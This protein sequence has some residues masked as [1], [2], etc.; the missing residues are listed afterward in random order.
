MWL[1]TVGG[2]QAIAAGAMLLS[3]IGVVFTVAWENGAFA[4]TEIQY[5]TTPTS[6]W[7]RLGV[8]PA[9]DN[10]FESTVNKLTRGR[11]YYLRMRHLKPD[12]TA[13]TLWSKTIGAVWLTGNQPTDNATFL[14]GKSDNTII[15][16]P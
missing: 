6:T 16:L 12:N 9:G 11:F 13:L 2:R 8:A 7:T 3:V 14:V 1:R 5:A 4:P 15:K 10:A